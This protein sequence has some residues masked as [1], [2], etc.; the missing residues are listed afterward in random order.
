MLLILASEHVRLR[1]KEMLFLTRGDIG[2]WETWGCSRWETDSTSSS[3]GK[4]PTGKSLTYSELELQYFV[5]LTPKGVYFDRF[6]KGQGQQAPG[7]KAGLMYRRARFVQE[8]VQLDW[9]QVRGTRVR[10]SAHRAERVSETCLSLSTLELV[11][12]S[13]RY[14]Q[15]SS[16]SF[17]RARS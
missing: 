12:I 14:L 10:C 7:I 17:M 2:V 4:D 6:A 16:K 1:K 11:V 5:L 3:P 9:V 13:T 15:V 8:R